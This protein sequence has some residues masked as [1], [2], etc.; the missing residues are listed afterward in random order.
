MQIVSGYADLDKYTGC[1][2]EEA[3]RAVISALAAY[4]ILYT[5]YIHTHT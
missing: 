3:A 5:I 4:Y 2:E 1:C